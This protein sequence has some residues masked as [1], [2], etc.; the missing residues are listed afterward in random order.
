MVK[1]LICAILLLTLCFSLCAIS[2]F[3]LDKMTA[4]LINELEKASVYLKDRDDQKAQEQ[5]QIVLDKWAKY[6]P[7]MSIF[8]D[9]S[10]L[11]DLSCDIP[12]IKPLSYKGNEDEAVE[13]SEHC[14][15]ALREIMEEQKISFANI[16]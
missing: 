8:L 7:V 11:E 9:H 14:I 5:I 12:S 1:R 6:R 4:D 10:Q 13:I 3:E 15:N 2:Y 16:L